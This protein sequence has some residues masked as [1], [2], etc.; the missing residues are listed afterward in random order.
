MQNNEKRASTGGCILIY[1]ANVEKGRMV[2]LHE[3][4]VVTRVLNSINDGIMSLLLLPRDIAQGQGEEVDGQR[5]DLLASLHP[6]LYRNWELGSKSE[7]V[8]CESEDF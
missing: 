7:S 1:K 4:P 3:K 5:S 8:Q 2:L 6:V